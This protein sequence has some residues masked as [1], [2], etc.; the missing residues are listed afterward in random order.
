MTFSTRGLAFAAIVLLSPLMGGCEETP[1]KTAA[2]QAVPPSVSVVK[3]E[4]RDM[5]PSVNL[6]AL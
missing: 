1:Q 5:R 4:T 3:A 2:P 6:K